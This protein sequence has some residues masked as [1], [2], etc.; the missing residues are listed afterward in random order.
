MRIHQLFIATAL[1]SVMMLGSCSNEQDEVQQDRIVIATAPVEMRLGSNVGAVATRSA[2]DDSETID[3]LGVFALA[4]HELSINQAPAAI[5]WWGT[6]ETQ[7]TACR[8]FNIEAKKTGA[9][10]SWIDEDA[11][12]YYPMTQFYAYDFYTYY[13]RVADDQLDKSNDNELYVDYKL[14]GKTDILW[15]RAASMETT[16]YSAAYFTQDKAHF[17]EAEYLPKLNLRHQLTRLVFYAVPAPKYN[18]DA[19]PDYTAAKQMKVISIKVV[20]AYTDVRLTIADLAL[21]SPTSMVTGCATNSTTDESWWR[22]RLVLRSENRDTITLADQPIADSVQ[23]EFIPVMVPDESTLPGG[24][25]LGESMMLYPQTYYKLQIVLQ[26]TADGLYHVSEIP[27]L[28]QPGGD[29]FIAGAQYKVVLRV[30]GPTEL[31]VRASLADW[32]D[33]G[34]ITVDMH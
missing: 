25:Q 33:G 7:V 17:T 23:P 14:D 9:L 5:Q 3:T 1:A 28:I 19:E 16:G 27:L 21:D 6:D 26:N 12:Y 18:G 22:D 8:L 2:L 31:S 11:H 10:V 24:V 30:G 20:N 15:G 29:P 34:N 32:D 13:P 4:R